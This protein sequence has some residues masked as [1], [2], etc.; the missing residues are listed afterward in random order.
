MKLYRVSVPQGSLISPVL[1]IYH[2]QNLK[3]EIIIKTNRLT[4]VLKP[5]PDQ[6]AACLLPRPP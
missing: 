5:Q 6:S 1:F 3:V 4:W 2:V